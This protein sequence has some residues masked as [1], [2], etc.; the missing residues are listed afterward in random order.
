MT[1][2]GAGVRV[3][4]LLVPLVTGA[5]GG[6]FIHLRSVDP[7]ALRDEALARETM[8]A[9]EDA[10]GFNVAGELSIPAIRAGLRAPG[11]YEE[12][13]FSGGQRQGVRLDVNNTCNKPS[14]MAA[15]LRAR[16]FRVQPLNREVT[17]S[18]VRELAQPSEVPGVPARLVIV[19]TS[20]HRSEQVALENFRVLESDVSRNCYS[21]PVGTF[22]PVPASVDG[23]PP[24]FGLHV[25]A[26]PVGPVANPS[27]DAVVFQRG[28]VVAVV[29]TASVLAPFPPEERQRLLALVSQ[30]VATKLAGP[31]E[32]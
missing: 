5:L 15:V 11:V 23:A 2:P 9:P 13:V 28:R 31:P 22:E 14:G 1:A 27:A 12:D 17:A 19:Q 18:T 6:A 25:T 30:R 16:L 21:T 29:A 32:P 8:V 20:V 4:R 3:L 7:A 10:P 26:P 24:A